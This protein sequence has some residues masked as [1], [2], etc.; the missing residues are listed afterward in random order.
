MNILMGEWHMDQSNSVETPMTPEL[1]Q[2]GENRPLMSDMEAQR[3][4]RAV[5]RV[6]YMSQDRYDLSSASKCMS[7]SMANPRVGDEM[8]I[9]RVI[10]YLRKYPRCINHMPFQDSGN[11]LR[12]MVDSDWAGDINNRRSTSGGLILLGKHV[13]CHW[14]KLQ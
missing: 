1:T 8:L 13:L 5:A 12:I 11:P 10:R 14:S 3:Y 4:R 7:Q 9:K 2:F 6:N